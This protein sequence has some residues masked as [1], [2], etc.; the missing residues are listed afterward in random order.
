MTDFVNP[1]LSNT[2]AR[3]KAAEAMAAAQIDAATA[4][5]DQILGPDGPV[6]AASARFKL[7]VQE[8]EQSVTE[9]LRF[10]DALAGDALAALG[11][12][13]STVAETFPLIE[14]AAVS[15]RPEEPATA[16][17]VEEPTTLPLPTPEESPVHED[18]AAEAEATSSPDDPS[19]IIDAPSLLDVE[20]VAVAANRPVR[21][22]EPADAATG[23]KKPAAKRGKPKAR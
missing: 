13:V 21:K 4:S 7:K 19:G 6:A 3:L 17:P 8:L 20:A 14:P 5:L 9:T 18:E 1:G 23:A 2:V 12:C 15:P 10:L 22:G 11:E 16:E